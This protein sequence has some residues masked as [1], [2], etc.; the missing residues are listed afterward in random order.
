[1]DSDKYHSWRTTSNSFFWLHGLSGCGKTVL[2]SSV[3]HQLQSE[4]PQAIIAYH[5]FDVNGGDGQGVIQMLRSLLFQLRSK[6]PAA[7]ETL[8]AL[9]VQCDNGA[10]QPTTRQLLKQFTSIL[11]LIDEAFVVIDGLDECNLPDNVISWLKDLN[12]VDRDSLRLLVTSRKQGV[13]SRVIDDW[14]RQDQLHAV[15]TNETDK[16]I[17]S[18]IHA[19]I[20]ESREFA[21]W[22]AQTGLR[23]QV[24]N[25][26]L[27]RS[28]GM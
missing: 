4:N 12:G 11:D 27:Q 10:R 14:P 9:F 22:N 18:Y 2:A 25:A 15:Q 19:R 16:D 3:I 20:F 1:L 8:Q 28:N 26:V 6:H 5:Y 21:K 24:K 7:R 17:A 13:L 23:E